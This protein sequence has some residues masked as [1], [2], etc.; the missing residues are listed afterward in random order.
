[1]IPSTRRSKPGSLLH[2]EQSAFVKYKQSSINKD[3]ETKSNADD[4][5]HAQG[6]VTTDKAQ[7]EQPE[8]IKEMDQ[9][10]KDAEKEL[11]QK[12][13]EDT[14]S[15]QEG[16]QIPMNEND[17]EKIIFL[18]KGK[19]PQNSTSVNLSKEKTG[20]ESAKLSENPIAQQKGKEL[21]NNGEK[22]MIQKDEAVRWA[23]ERVLLELEKI[24]QT[25]IGVSQADETI[26]EM[27]DKAATNSGE[28]VSIP[29]ESI[30]KDILSS[31]EK[32][33]LLRKK[34]FTEDRDENHLNIEVN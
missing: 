5:H 12:N 11:T 23:K 9:T 25:Q 29:Q 24:L 14:L 4:L 34:Q 13:E 26:G 21:K 30:I 1:M 32:E 33:L 28:S 6:T 17:A 7:Q 8:P 19:S 31:K 18:A 20:K 22:M 16:N 2:S 3:K 27:R 10:E 15:R